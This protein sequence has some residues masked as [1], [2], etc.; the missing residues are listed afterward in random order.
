MYQFWMKRE[1]HNG[2]VYYRASQHW[3]EIM[4]DRMLLRTEVKHECYN[5]DRL[6]IKNICYMFV[7]KTLHV[8]NFN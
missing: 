1:A 7:V 8:C 4:K 3:S 5:C 6:I 2:S